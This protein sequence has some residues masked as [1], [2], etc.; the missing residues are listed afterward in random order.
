MIKIKIQKCKISDLKAVT[1]FYDKVTLFLTKTV[2]YPKWSY[3]EYPSMDSVKKAISDGV[4]FMCIEDN[5]VLGAFILNDNPDGAYEKG[6]WQIDLNRG[7][8]LIIHTLAA[9]PDLHNQGTG[10]FMVNYCISY[11]KEH[12]FKAIRLDVVPE[13][14]PAKR[15]YEKLGFTFAGVKDL[16]RDIEE[17]PTFDLYELNFKQ[18]Y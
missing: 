10:K 17:I 12:G 11:A 5:V 2:N 18:G 16:E 7:E 14:I 8:Y 15:L 6:D 3:G 1:A 13:N 4:Q 9:D